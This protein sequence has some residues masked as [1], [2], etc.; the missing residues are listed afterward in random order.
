MKTVPLLNLGL[1]SD[2]VTIRLAVALR[3][4]VIIYEPHSCRYGHRV[5][6]IWSPLVLL[7]PV[8]TVLAAFPVAL[9]NE[10]C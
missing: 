2:D 5:D 1:H 10:V 6:R 7:S 3:V 4:G 9:T 8:G